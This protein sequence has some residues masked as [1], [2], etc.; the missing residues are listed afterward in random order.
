MSGYAHDVEAALSQRK[1]LD[2]RAHRPWP[3]PK[4]PWI[5]GQTWERL[6]F[7]HW[8]VPLEKLR[9]VVHPN[10]P[11]DTFDG[12]AWV[13]VTPF[14]V[15][16]LHVRGAPPAPGLSSFHEINVRTYATVDGK[17]G[18]YFF[19]LDAASRLAVETARRVYRVP[20]FEAE[21]GVE[22]EADRV[23]YT[24]ERTQRG[25]PPAGFAAEYE[26]NG[27]VHN[28]APDSFEWWM[29]ERYCLYTLDDD[30]R[31]QRGEIHHPPW[32]L[33]AAT[34]DI[35]HNTMGRQIGIDLDSEP[36][37]HFAQRQDVV[38]WALSPVEDGG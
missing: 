8:R 15:T 20:Y 31:V 26:P 2:E 32:P 29:A 38:F 10:I 22:E 16:G 34:V 23:R 9:E 27:P 19:S 4:A 35:A 21:I 25:G 14:T 3:L 37:A 7:A 36:T 11:I 33:Q 5:M 18:I 6:L 17:P 28:A 24:H 13:G 1:A 12:S 30:Q